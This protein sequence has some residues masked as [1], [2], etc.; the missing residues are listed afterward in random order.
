M[1]TLNRENLN[2]ILTGS[3]LLGSGGGGS[4]STGK[5]FINIILKQKKVVNLIDT[6]SD[7]FGFV[8][9]DIGAV[10]AE[11]SRQDIAI[12]N[13]YDKLNAYYKSV[14][15]KECTC[16]FPVETGPENTFAPIVLAAKKGISVFDGDGGGRAVPQ[17]QLCSYAAA[18]INPSPAA[19]TNDQHDSLLVFCDDAAGMDS[20][21]RPVTAAAQ[22]GNSASLALFPASVKELANAC[23]GGS[24]SFALYTGMLIKAL[25]TKNKKLIQS[26]LPFVNKKR[27]CLLG[28]G[29]VTNVE[30]QVSGAFDIGRVVL[31]T[32]EGEEITI[33]TQNENLIAFSSKDSSPMAVAPHSIAYLKNKSTPITNSEIKKNDEISLLCIE[34]APELLTPRVKSG[35]QILLGTLGYAGKVAILKSGNSLVPLGTLLQSLA[36]D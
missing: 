29:K 23:V 11:E 6:V 22:F 35:F 8:L 7:D 3:A 18:G 15:K 33:Y 20:L 16:I 9:A 28:S 12:Y 19:I 2:Y 14:Y 31:I 13:A 21:L 34:A 17:I 26:S 10:S 5:N 25:Q 4:I 1:K 32:H 36:K 27:A 24:I 30:D